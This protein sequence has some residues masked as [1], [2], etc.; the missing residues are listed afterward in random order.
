MRRAVWPE[1]RASTRTSSGA[2]DLVTR[3][4]PPG[5]E[6][7]T[8]SASVSAA[9]STGRPGST[10]TA[11][12]GGPSNTDARVPR[13]AEVEV[14]G[15]DRRPALEHEQKSLSVVGL[16][17]QGLPR[18]EPVDAEVDELPAG[19]L[20]RDVDDGPVRG[21]WNRAAEELPRGPRS[22]KAH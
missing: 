17:G 11:G 1:P 9:T 4:G 10:R 18:P 12:G 8:T 3:T 19:R 7:T 16:A 2:M 21:R 5:A 13:D 14:P 20:D 15:A 6:A 22:I